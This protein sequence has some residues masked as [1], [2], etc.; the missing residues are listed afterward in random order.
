LSLF[1]RRCAPI[2]AALLVA[3][4]IAPASASATVLPTTIS[5]SMTLT[6]AAS[7]YTGTSTTISEGVTVTVE[8]GALVKLSGTLT[9]KGTLDVDGTAEA[10]AVFTS[11]TNSAP[12][13]WTGVVLQAGAGASSLRHAEVRYAKTGVAVSG[14]ISPEILDS[15]I[16]HG[17]SAG[18]SVSGGGS[19]EIAR[20]TIADNGGTGIGFSYTGSANRLNI[21]DNVV[22]SN[23]GDGIRVSPSSGASFEPI[24][25]SGNEVK[26]NG[27]TAVYFQGPT[28][29]PDI[30]ENTLSGNAKNGI[31]VSGTVAQS[32]TWEDRGYPVV[33]HS[34]VTVS[35]GTAL[36]L[37]PGLIVKIDNTRLTVNGTLIADGTVA[38]PITFTSIKEDLGGDTNG[39]G[40]ASMPSPGDWV[41]VDFSATS[42]GMLDHTRVR[43][44]G[45]SSSSGDY[46][47][48]V[49]QCPCPTPPAITNSLI[50]HSKNTGLKTN[51]SSP[52]ITGNTISHNA[53][54][55]VLL[56]GGAPE[57]AYNEISDNG[58]RGVFYNALPTASGQ[59]NIH[60]N[61]V[62]HNGESGIRVSINTAPLVKSITLA[63]NE[64]NENGGQA[65]F[66]HGG[67]VPPDIDDNSLSGNAKNGIWVSGTVA[68]STTW[69]DRGYPF[70]SHSSSIKIAA[71]ATLT[72][73]PG[74]TIKGEIRGIE[75]NGTLIADGTA[76]E[77]ITF[78]S[79]KDDSVDGDTNGNGSATLPAPGDWPGIYFPEAAGD[80]L[81]YVAFHYAE[82]A[83]DIEELVSMFIENSDFIYNDQAIAVATTADM[84]PAL[85]ALP[86]VP[87][88]LSFVMAYDVWFGEAGYPSSSIDLTDVLGAVLPEEYGS[89]FQAF[90]SLA[91]LSAPLYPGGD[92]IPFAIYSCPEIGIPPT[93]MTPVILTNI[94]PEPWFTAL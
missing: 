62:E 47:M 28:I 90:T 87:P 63:D 38:E 85:G 6:A 39:D 26:S 24:D 94:P 30:D 9:S 89:L 29:P 37:Q 16:H 42:G 78:T 83:I 58:H 77:P 17:T 14:G 27:G 44:G 18:I 53:S 55:G 32:T 72:L 66:F 12:G 7:P 46:A 35:S 67:T 84:D 93:P 74:S 1:S 21:H 49:I 65:I 56:H 70:V 75:V 79:I 71:A 15:F 69:E 11:A 76:T 57:L 4:A 68:Q 13:Q 45:S 22:Q 64:V 81:S 3:L 36:T 91:E 54:D 51:V 88:Y 50:R 92:S 59:I 31:W 5:E 20:N 52:Q 33:V 60:D 80:E 34:G 25:F 82:A 61:L 8:P 19:A 2:A 43:Y 41:K 48:V 73:A 10:P 40:A 86:C 23:K